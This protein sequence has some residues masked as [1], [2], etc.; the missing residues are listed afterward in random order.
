MADRQTEN[1]NLEF[2]VQKEEEL[3]KQK[4]QLEEVALKTLSEDLEEQLGEL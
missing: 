4:V 1:K 3:K 2:L